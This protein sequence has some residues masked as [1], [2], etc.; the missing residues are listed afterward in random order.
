VCL[1]GIT[2]KLIGSANYTPF[3]VITL[4]YELPQKK[5]NLGKDRCLKKDVTLRWCASAIGGANDESTEQTLT[6]RRN[7]TEIPE[8]HESRKTK[9]SG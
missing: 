1:I 6:V 8:S 4:P 7:P 3:H 5:G 2:P 9:D